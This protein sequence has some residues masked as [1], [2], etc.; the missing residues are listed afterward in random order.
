MQKVWALNWKHRWCILPIWPVLETISKAKERLPSWLNTHTDL[1][2]NVVSSNIIGIPRILTCIFYSACF[3]TTEFTSNSF[4]V[5]FFT[6]ADCVHIV[7]RRLFAYC[8]LFQTRFRFLQTEQIKSKIFSLRAL[9]ITFVKIVRFRT[10]ISGVIRFNYLPDQ[11]FEMRQS[12]KLLIRGFKVL[13]YYLLL[14]LTIFG[15]RPVG[16]ID[17]I[18]NW[19]VKTSTK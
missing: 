4:K 5:H 18:K 2:E 19:T 1:Q 14:P 11:R 9:E 3:K 7:P 12:C 10:E 17:F 13:D 15:W 8:K 6:T 16:Q